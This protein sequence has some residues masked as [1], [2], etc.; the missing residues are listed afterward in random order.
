M[1]LCMDETVRLAS[2]G[3]EGA[4]GGRER[5]RDRGK[6]GRGGGGGGGKEGMRG[7][8]S[9]RRWVRVGN[10]SRFEACVCMRV[11]M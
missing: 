5:E 7:G 6:G 11:S 10:G 4:E 2:G 9:Y 8:M 3:G 1:S